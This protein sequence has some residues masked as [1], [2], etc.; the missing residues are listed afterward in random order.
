ME[1]L[2]AELER[3]ESEYSKLT[4][5]HNRSVHET[6]ESVRKQKRLEVTSKQQELKMKEIST[7]LDAKNDLVGQASSIYYHSYNLFV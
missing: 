2:T 4:D 7:E 5:A 6:E 1:R 3:K